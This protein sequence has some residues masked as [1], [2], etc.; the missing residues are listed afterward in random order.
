MKKFLIRSCVFGCI[1]L[2]FFIG[3]ESSLR[4]IPNPYLFK[5]NLMTREAKAVKTLVIGSSVADYGIF[6]ACLGDSA[7]SLAI[8]GEWIKY[9]EASLMRYIDNMH[10]LETVFWGICFQALWMDDDYLGC[11]IFSKEVEMGEY[12]KKAEQRIYR[13]F[14]LGNY[15]PRY[16]VECI[17][18]L[19][20]SFEKWLKHYLRHQPTVRCDSLGFDYTDA[21]SERKSGWEKRWKQSVEMHSAQLQVPTARKVYQLNCQRLARVAQICRERNIRLCI[22]VPPTHSLYYTHV[23]KEQ[24]SLMYSALNELCEK[25]DNVWLF[26]Y[27]QDSRFDN[28]CFFD[29]NHLSDVGAKRFTPILWKDYWEAEKVQN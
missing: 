16:E 15:D 8:S 10:R 27:F 18:S 11:G 7:Y 17:Q 2:L 9:N 23:G 25:Y 28:D 21:L 12:M 1:I 24:L 5:D 26:D 13:G 14:I 4:R 3:F 29:V 22:V 19:P 20:T 6:P